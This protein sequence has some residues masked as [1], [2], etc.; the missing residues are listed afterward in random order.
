[1]GWQ[2]RVKTLFVGNLPY[3]TT[4]TN[5]TQWFHA[6][7]IEVDSVSLQ[8]DRFTGRL[9]GFAY[10]VVPERQMKTAVRECNGRPFGG[11][12]LVVGQAPGYESEQ[13][14]EVTVLSCH[15]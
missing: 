4:G 11:R 1:V 3:D 5:L 10:V 12:T 6:A 15:S 14:G 13:A 9:R 7:G 8:L 2:N